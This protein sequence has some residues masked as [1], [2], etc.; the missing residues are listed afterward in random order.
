MKRKTPR[1]LCILIIACIVISQL[2]AG[3]GK[4]EQNTT[5]TAVQ[6]T[7]ATDATTQ[8][9]QREVV[10]V[11]MFTTDTTSEGKEPLNDPISQ[12]I[13]KRFGLKFKFI[14]GDSNKQ[15]LTIASGDIADI[16]MYPVSYE[17]Q[18]LKSGYAMPL[19]DLVKEKGQDILKYHGPAV[20]AIKQ[21]HSNGT[22]QMFFWP[23]Y[24]SEKTPLKAED[25]IVSFYVRWDYYKELGYPEV[26]TYDGVLDLLKQMQ[27][28]HPKTED[29][30]KVYGL[31]YWSDWGAYWAWFFPI[32]AAE[33]NI[34]HTDEFLMSQ[35]NTMKDAFSDPDSA[36]WKNVKWLNNAQ[37]MGLLDPEFATQKYNNYMDKLKAGQ[38][39]TTWCSW[40]PA[41]ANKYFY[42]DGSPEKGLE[43]LLGP[44]P[45]VARSERM[46][47]VL[48]WNEYCW[49]SKSCKYADR[50]IEM[51]NF[52]ASYEGTRF[53]ASGIEG[54]HW[55]MV[56]GKP[57][58][59][60]EITE[61]RTTDANFKWTTGIDLYQWFKGFL[62]GVVDPKDG[63]TLSISSDPS[64]YAAKMLPVEKEFCDYH[65]VTTRGEAMDKWISAGK[66]KDA[67]TDYG[68]TAFMPAIP[69]DFHKVNMKAEQYLTKEMQKCIY[70]K[71]DEEFEKQKD[72]MIKEIISYGYQDS[73]KWVADEWAKAAAKMAEL[74]AK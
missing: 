68:I 17:D 26:T 53:F 43:L 18:I 37:K 50:I 47:S 4:A 27:D 70:A 36:M 54:V 20:E 49:I 33:G 1:V 23:M 71:T 67:F 66:V 14:T 28:K 44:A 22:N 16:N 11:T 62:G 56:N 38:V 34:N 25:P 65:G 57:Q 21:Y 63:V 72:L 51:V 13:A 73:A 15:A 10:E 29:G 32:V 24:C 60:P 35:D 30:K 39:L 2:L 55:D 59:K 9:E 46:S 74:R 48:G 7:A 19:D 8:A 31:S 45:Y 41:E 5:D 69:D 58:E 42:N 6:T 52:G 64:T 12:E 61:K 40:Q 3:C